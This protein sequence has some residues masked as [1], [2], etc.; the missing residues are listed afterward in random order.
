[1]IVQTARTVSGTMRVRWRHAPQRTEKAALALDADAHAAL[2]VLQ[3]TTVVGCPTLSTI[4]GMPDDVVPSRGGTDWYD[5]FCGLYLSI[6]VL[7]AHFIESIAFVVAQHEALWLQDHLGRSNSACAPFPKMSETF[8]YA[9]CLRFCLYRTPT[10]A[11]R[12]RDKRR[13]LLP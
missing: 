12:R 10:T 5:V 2:R 11:V 7:P 3:C 6:E 1:M 9:T 13:K 4:V 8:Q